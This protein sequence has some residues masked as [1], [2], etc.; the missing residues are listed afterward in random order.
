MYNYSVKIT[1]DP[2]K[3]LKTLEERGIDFHHVGVVFEGKTLTLTDDRKDYGEA[4]FQSYGYLG[5]RMVMVV[6]T[7]RGQARHIISMRYCHES[8]AN[9]V[10]PRMG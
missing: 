7:Q 6:W 2:A 8:E 1:C 3:R 5:E 4:R 9:K 10:R